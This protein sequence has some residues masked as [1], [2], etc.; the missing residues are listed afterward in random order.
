MFK[1]FKRYDITPVAS[2]TRARSG[3]SDDAQMQRSS[4]AAAAAAAAAGDAGQAWST[5]NFLVASGSDTNAAED[6]T[7]VHGLSGHTRDSHITD[8]ARQGGEL[9]LVQSSAPAAEQP[10]AAPLQDAIPQCVP[11]TAKVPPPGWSFYYDSL[12]KQQQAQPE[13]AAASSWA[14]SSMAD[15]EGL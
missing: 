11:V 12:T 4:A 13:A 7:A 8:G 10:A 14:D 6:S 3:V 15:A 1:A 5:A 2:V 9:Q